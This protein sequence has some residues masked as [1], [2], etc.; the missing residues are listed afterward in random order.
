[1]SENSFPS[2]FAPRPSPLAPPVSSTPHA[3][4]P[5]L[6]V[7]DWPSTLTA[8]EEAIALQIRMTFENNLP[9][10]QTAVARVG[11]LI[12]Q[13]QSAAP[14][15]PEFR[16]QLAALAKKHKMA[17]L[18]MILKRQE[19]QTRIRKIRVGRKLARTYR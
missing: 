7:F 5:T 14:V 11:E 9:V 16:P 10:A 2:P 19:T 17:Q 3:L 6:N 8:L 13:L 12:G 18:A 15:P 4:G 1:M